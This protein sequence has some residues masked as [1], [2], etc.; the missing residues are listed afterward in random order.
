MKKSAQALG[1]IAACLAFLVLTGCSAQMASSQDQYEEAWQK[2]LNSQAWKDALKG[3]ESDIYSGK[4]EFHTGTEVIEESKDEKTRK[5]DRESD[6]EA[7]YDVLV[8]R[9]YL[10]IIAEAEKADSRLERE[11]IIRNAQA[12]KRETRG[13]KTFDQELELV[14]KRYQA[15]RKMLNGLKSWKI[16]SEYGTDDLD[17][18]KAEHKEAVRKMLLNGKDEKA[19]VN[20]LIYRLADLY[21]FEDGNEY[22]LTGS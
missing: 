17:F 16:F 8:R 20:F 10:K 14:N 22:S 15:H 9:A 1:P 21:H 5:T 11:Y 12:L 13:A 19:I 3:N 18:F 7:R 4:K 6:F 2:V